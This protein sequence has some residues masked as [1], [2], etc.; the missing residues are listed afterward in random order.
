MIFSNFNKMK[1]VSFEALKL[2]TFLE[3]LERSPTIDNAL[4]LLRELDSMKNENFQFIQDVFLSRLLIM[5]DSAD[6]L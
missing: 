1:K 5:M 4:N 3:H 2:K 6:G